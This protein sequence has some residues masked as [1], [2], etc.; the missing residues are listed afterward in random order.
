MTVEK[1]QRFAVHNFHSLE[2]ATFSPTDYSKLKFGSD[3]VARR[4]GYELATS[5][6]AAHSDA[7]IANQLVVISSP[8]NFVENAATV[9][10][11][12]FVNKLNELLVNA[13][14]RSVE[15][16]VIHRKVSYTNDYGF[17]SKQKR[18]GLI[19]NDLF[20]LNKDFIAGKMLIFIDD[21]RITGTHEEKLEE[22]LRENYITNPAFFLYYANYNGNRPDIEAAINFA[23]ISNLN[24]YLNLVKSDEDHHVIIRPIKYILSQKKEVLKEVLPQFSDQFFE[25]VYYGCLAEGYYKIPSYQKNFQLLIDEKKRRE[26]VEARG[27]RETTW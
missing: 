10:T 7:L 14:G 2:S 8:Y 4:F 23:A 26:V 1:Y 5:F 25:K 20:Y 9:M 21:V 24:D 3:H 18:K 22:I 6:F 12:H 11:R 17:L 15:Y 27:E 19:D 13:Q 16:S